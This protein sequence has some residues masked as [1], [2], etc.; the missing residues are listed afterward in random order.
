MI[1]KTVFDRIENG[2]AILLPDNLSIEISIPISK[3]DNNCFKGQSISV[4]IDDNGVVSLL[5]DVG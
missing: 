1:I 5:N 3:W 2:C 4:A